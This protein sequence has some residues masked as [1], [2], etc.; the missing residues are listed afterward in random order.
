M[1]NKYI[2]TA[3]RFQLADIVT[4]K[5][6]FLALNSWATAIEANSPVWPAVDIAGAPEELYEA[7]VEFKDVVLEDIEGFLYTIKS[8][9]LLEYDD[10][11]YFGSHHVDIDKASEILRLFLMLEPEGTEWR[12]VCTYT[13]DKLLDGDYNAGIMVITSSTIAYT[14]IEELYDNFVSLGSTDDRKTYDDENDF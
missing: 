1:Y 9:K 13:S 2:S 3:K 6:L 11:L 12:V 7:L 8:F 14:E 10:E 5:K 4:A